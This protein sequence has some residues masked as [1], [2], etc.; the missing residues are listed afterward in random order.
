MCCSKSLANKKTTLEKKSGINLNIY[1]ICAALQSHIRINFFCVDPN[2]RSVA[3]Y[4]DL[5][6]LGNPGGAW[7]QTLRLPETNSQNEQPPENRPKCQKIE[8]EGVE[9]IEG[10]RGDNL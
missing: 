10:V 6:M 8:K 9:K 7:V 2:P 5:A 1:Q 4:G 3:V